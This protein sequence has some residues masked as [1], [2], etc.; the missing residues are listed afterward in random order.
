MSQEERWLEIEHGIQNEEEMGEVDG[1]HDEVFG[2]SEAPPPDEIDELTPPEIGES[3]GA[4]TEADTSEEA[5]QIT[6]SEQAEV[7]TETPAGVPSTPQEVEGFLSEE[8]M[9][10]ELT[11]ECCPE[12]LEIVHGRDDRVRVWNTRPYPWRTICHLEITTK[13]GGR[14]TCTG[15]FIGPRVVLTAGHCLYLHGS[16]GW[17]RSIR[18][19]PGRNVAHEPYGA[20]VGTYYISTKGWVNNRNSNYDYGVIV[21]PSNKKLGNTVGWMGLAS[22]SFGSLLG[23]LVNSSGYPGDKPYGTQWWNSN[24]I[25]AVTT[26]RIYYQIDTYGGQSGSPV[27]RY[28]NGQRHII[29]IHT[30]GGAP[31]NGATR[32]VKPVFDNLVKWKKL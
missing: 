14:G 17:A 8:A 2:G 1:G 5:E 24:R 19:I 23:L 20:A 32:I 9:L 7:Y 29:G 30:T 12:F 22:L 10:Q 4:G 31:Y 25:M 15:S 26:R 3:G 16:G 13:T 27:W 6:D 18:V 21:L 28:K 11:V